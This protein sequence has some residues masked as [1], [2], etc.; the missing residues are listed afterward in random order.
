MCIMLTC[1][2]FIFQRENLKVPSIYVVKL[3]FFI[4][5]VFKHQEV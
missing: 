3:Q 1:K 5:K 4:D 2:Q